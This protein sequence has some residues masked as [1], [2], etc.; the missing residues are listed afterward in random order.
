MPHANRTTRV[1]GS[2]VNARLSI[3][4][5]ISIMIEETNFVAIRAFF[6]LLAEWESKE[7]KNANL[8]P[9]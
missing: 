1:S 4:D 7:P 3:P 8:N 2:P 6:E 9:S 5:P